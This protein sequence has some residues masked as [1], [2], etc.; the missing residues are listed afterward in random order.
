MTKEQ[1]KEL[2]DLVNEYKGDKDLVADVVENV[3]KAIAEAYVEEH[4]YQDLGI[5][6]ETKIYSGIIDVAKE[7]LDLT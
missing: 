1:E 4:T 3:R 7:E 2:Y 5:H 6:I